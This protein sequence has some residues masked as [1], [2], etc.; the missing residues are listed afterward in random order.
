MILGPMFKEINL[1]GDASL[2]KISTHLENEP[3]W[4]G[5]HDIRAQEEPPGIDESWSMGGM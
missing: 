3:E 1:S 4:R 5:W 2:P